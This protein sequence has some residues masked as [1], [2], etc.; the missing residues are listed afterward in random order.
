[1]LPGKTDYDSFTVDLGGAATT[2]NSTLGDW[3]IRDLNRRPRQAGNDD[4]FP[5]SFYIGAVTDGNYLRF[6][7]DA[8]I[9]RVNYDDFVNRGVAIYRVASSGPIAGAE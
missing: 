2:V 5:V 3:A 8:S 1:M 4:Y 6:D 9:L 7:S